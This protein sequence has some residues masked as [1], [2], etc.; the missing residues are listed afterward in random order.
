M[1]RPALAGGDVY[2]TQLLTPIGLERLQVGDGQ[3]F[4][5]LAL[6]RD[7]E[8]GAVHRLL[9]PRKTDLNRDEHLPWRSLVT[10]LRVIP[11]ALVERFGEG[12]GQRHQIESFFS[13]L[14]ACIY[15]KDRHASCGRDAR[16]LDLIAAAL[17][18]NTHAW[19]HLAYRHPQQA[20][21]LVSDLPALDDASGDAGP[22]RRLSATALH[23]GHRTP[24]SGVTYRVWRA[25]SRTSSPR[26]APKGSSG[27]TQGAVVGGEVVLVLVSV[28]FMQNRL[29]RRLAGQL[30]RVPV[31][32][33]GDVAARMGCAA[34][35]VP[36]RPVWGS[37]PPCCPS[38]TR[39]GRRWD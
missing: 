9:R 23:R 24:S 15:R 35:P 22:D 37:W 5:R 38:W 39:G 29:Q 25:P 6:A 3:Y 12:Y 2:K 10:N 18:H 14:E 31:R 21:R 36:S 26:R 30:R 17:L 7:C 11:D 8:H 34:R 19:A 16:L 4:L 28:G 27:T 33:C 1:D 13:W 32:R 20:E